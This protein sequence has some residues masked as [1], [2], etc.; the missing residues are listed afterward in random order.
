MATTVHY[1]LVQIHNVTTRQW[2]QEMVYDE[3]RTDVLCHRFRLRFEGIVHAGGFPS[4]GPWAAR[5]AGQGSAPENYAEIRSLLGQARLPLVVAATDAA[6]VERILLTALP[7]G[8]APGAADM[9]VENG[10]KPTGLAITHIAGAN[11]FRVAFSIECAKLECMRATGTS[12][13]PFVLNNRWSV[14]E[15]MDEAKFI[16][17]TIEGQMQLSA[18]VAVLGNDFRGLVVP[19]LEAGFRR[20]RA[21]IHVDPSGLTIRYRVTDRQVHTAAPWP[22][23]KMDVTHTEEAQGETAFFSDVTVRLEGSPAADRRLLILRAVQILEARLAFLANRNDPKEKAAYFIESLV[24]TEH[25][26]DQNLVEARA[27]IMRSP[28]ADKEVDFGGFFAALRKVQG[29]DLELLPVD[30]EPARYDSRISSKPPLYGYDPQG[31][32]RR[33]IV[34]WFLHCYLQHPCVDR[35]GIAQTTPSVSTSES[36]GNELRTQIVERELHTVGADLGNDFSDEANQ[37]V[38]TMARMVSI[39]DTDDLTVA[40]PL[41]RGQDAGRSKAS[42]SLI[43]LAPSLVRRIIEFDCE[44]AGSWPAIPAPLSRYQDSKNGWATRVRW[45]ITPQPPTLA[46]DGRTRIYRVG[47]RY[48]YVLDREPVSGDPLRVGVLPFTRYRSPETAFD[49]RE[50]F[51]ADVGP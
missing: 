32:E 46:A 36:E 41:A 14:A 48:E 20:A 1:G 29:A 30:G 33:P 34:L 7:L 44:A 11:C 10:P 39:Y 6:G 28:K 8:M 2:E 47:G 16:E 4:P 43:R 26:G 15:A 12:A 45:R 49:P 40:L 31:G 22:A 50:S 17:R 21:E 51:S 42:V 27:R 37:T 38:Y 3:S 19:G 35:H 18:P 9:D 25:L 23:E 24:I 5:G 13:V